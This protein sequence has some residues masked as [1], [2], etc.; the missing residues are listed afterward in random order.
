[1]RIR[2]TIPPNAATRQHQNRQVIIVSHSATTPARDRLEQI[3]SRLNDRRRE[4]KAFVRL[5]AESARA[6]ADAADRRRRDGASLGP[7]DGK[8]VSILWMSTEFTDG[9]SDSSLGAGASE[10]VSGT[11]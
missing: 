8:I 5:Y 3:L 10:V 6:E 1:M 2:A 9:P 7:L 4:E 11:G